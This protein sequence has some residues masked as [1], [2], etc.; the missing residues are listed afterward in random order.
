MGMTPRKRQDAGFPEG[1]ILAGGEG[2]RVDLQDKGLMPLRGKPAV[3]H[4]LSTLQACCGRVLI[5]ANRNLDTY[6]DLAPG[7]VVADLRSGYHGPLAGFEAVRSLVRA[8]CVLVLPCDMPD[9]TPRILHR[10]HAALKDDPALDAAYATTPK[11]DFYLV[12]ALRRRALCGIS[13]RLD[14]G[15]GAVRRWLKSLNAERV[16]FVGADAAALGNRNKPE[17]WTSR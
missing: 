11:D 2:R 13:E 4:V 8:D 15:D 3:R 10:L 6:R 7:L 9:V 12:S 17:D 5:S 14:A 16:P 1:L